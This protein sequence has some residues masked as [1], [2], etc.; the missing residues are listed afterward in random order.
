[1]LCV[2]E[3]NVKI[4]ETEERAEANPCAGRILRLRSGL[5]TVNRPPGQPP[6]VSPVELASR[7]LLAAGKNPRG[8]DTLGR[9]NNIEPVVFVGYL[10]GEDMA[11]DI[12]IVLIAV[13]ALVSGMAPQRVCRSSAHD[14]CCHSGQGLA[15]LTAGRAEESFPAQAARSCCGGGSAQAQA[16]SA[17]V[18]APE[19]N[20]ADCVRLAGS[21]CACRMLPETPARTSSN[22]SYDFAAHAETDRI[23]QPHHSLNASRVAAYP[24]TGRNNSPPDLHILLSTV[25]LLI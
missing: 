14:R 11:K 3:K 22:N 7:K 4:P 12:V 23:S 8:I 24:A 25:C 9:I 5:S 19:G 16:A 10:L 13:F 21:R 2:C 20:D 18:G 17:Q 6:P 15:D 1:M